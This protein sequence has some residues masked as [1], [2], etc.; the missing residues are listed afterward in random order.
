MKRIIIF[1]LCFVAVQTFGQSGF[2]RFYSKNRYLGLSVDSVFY[3]AIR[4]TNFTALQAGAMVYKSSNGKL[5]ISNGNTTGQKW[6]EIGSSGGGGTWGSITGTLS[7]Q[8]DLNTALNLRLLKSDTAT[9]LSPYL[10]DGDTVSILASARDRTTHT[11]TQAQSTIQ[12]LND[13]LR[14]KK[15]QAVT[16][17]SAAVQSIQTGTY[18]PWRGKAFWVSDY[19]SASTANDDNGTPY[20]ANALFTRYTYVPPLPLFTGYRKNG[21]FRQV[22]AGKASGFVYSVGGDVSSS[23]TGEILLTNMKDYSGDTTEFQSG[24]AIYDATPALIGNLQV[25]PLTGKKVKALGWWSGV[26]SY[27]NLPSGNSIQ[28]WISFLSNR[29]SFGGYTNYA[30]LYDNAPSSSQVTGKIW[31]IV[32]PQ[33]EQKHWF[34]GQVGIGTKFGSALDLGTQT[35][36]AYTSL[37][38]GDS[39]KVFIP[40]KIS[41]YRQTQITPVAGMFYYNI[42]S[43]RFFGYNGSSYKGIAWTGE[44]GGSGSGTVN[45]GTQY[46]LGYYASTGTSISEAAAITASRVLISDANGVPTHSSVTTTTLGYLDATSSIQTQINA[47]QATL[48]SGTSI[49]TVNGTSLLGSGDVSVG[50]ITG[51]GT[52]GYFPRFSSTSAI[53]NNILYGDGSRIGINT[54]SPNSSAMLD[55]SSTSMGFLMPRLTTIQMNAIST[56][57][58]GLQIY[59]TNENAVYVYYSSAWHKVTD[60]DYIT[61]TLGSVGWDITYD[62]LVREQG[63][64]ID[65]KSLRVRSSSGKLTVTKTT[66]DST[67]DYDLTIPSG[68]IGAT[69]LAS[70]AVTPGSYTSADI[71]IDADG[72]ITAA[73]NGSGS[74][75]NTALGNLAAVA[76]N[77]ALLPATTN[78]IA[79]GSSSKTWSDLFLGSGG[80]ID[81]NSDVQLIHGT[82]NLSLTGGNFTADIAVE[83]TV[84]GTGVVVGTTNTQVISN[85][86]WVPRVGSTT[87]SA[88][89]TINTDNYD[90]Y[91][92]TAQAADITSFTTN[93]SGTPNDGEILEI[94]ITGT[95]SRAITWGSSFVASTVAL[96][97]TTSGTTTLTVIFQYYTTSSYGNNKWVCVNSY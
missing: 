89:P 57:A 28:N 2:V 69:E 53:G 6:V 73:S 26:T 85:K 12:Y 43:S 39:T 3:N 45:S 86:R 41:T 52:A 44:G 14:S 51:S 19:D 29:Y 56:P 84:G 96:P 92:L 88:T 22:Y 50:T 34:G 66:T 21:Y 65:I 30:A 59:N 38:L 60:V 62:S 64:D 95:A 4:D 76:I 42:D 9:M 35:F 33:S 16:N 97:T 54:A 46:R 1:L 32:M 13:S 74:G 87:S 81:F 67:L 78:T 7:S 27:H 75:A 40:N 5:Y 71:T 94:Q 48:V 36:N 15:L 25:S 72:R 79:L 10:S 37:E 49:K 47:K 20:N 80:V 17:D 63:N 55:V 70:T 61:S 93:L 18:I 68:A 23:L 24:Y 91:K 58:T 31:G 82:N 83:S 8:T 77:T 11:G 90:I